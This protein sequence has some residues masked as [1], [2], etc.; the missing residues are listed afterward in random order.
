MIQAV[1]T[2]GFPH[3]AMEWIAQNIVGIIVTIVG[4]FVGMATTVAL[5]SWKISRELS[6]ISAS[7]HANGD[8]MEALAKALEQHETDFDMHIRDGSVHTT[9]EQRQAINARF[10]R[11]ENSIQTGH[12]TIEAKIDRVMDRLLTRA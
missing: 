8:K 2:G 1:L 5:V 6:S 7:S 11:I 4:W 9:L 12:A 3:V 10:D